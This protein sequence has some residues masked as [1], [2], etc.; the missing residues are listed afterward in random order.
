MDRL[1]SLFEPHGRVP[2]DELINP[3]WNELRSYV[4][5]AW[6]ALYSRFIRSDEERLPSP[7]KLVYRAESPS[8]GSI[9][10]LRRV[11]QRRLFQPSQSSP[12]L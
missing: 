5:D 6:L 7:Y 11:Q 10:T 2:W 1:E 4:E 12:Q 9:L 3:L 8:E